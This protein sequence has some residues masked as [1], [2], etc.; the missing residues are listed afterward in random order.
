MLCV[1]PDQSSAKGHVV[2][3]SKTEEKYIEMLSSEDSAYLFET[4]SALSRI[5]FEQFKAQGTN[6]LLMSGESDDNLN[7]RLALH[8]LPRWQ[9]DVLQ[10]LVWEP[11]RPNYNLDD[12]ASKIKD[13]AWKVKFEK[14]VQKDIKVEKAAGAAA[15]TVQ[16][17]IM[18]AIAMI[19][20]R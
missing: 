4:A 8:I 5:I 20:G 18:D 7:G 11:K 14:K 13:K 19:R 1:I 3:Y 15:S 17:E 9:N 2:I 6:I 16:K 12:V 10:G